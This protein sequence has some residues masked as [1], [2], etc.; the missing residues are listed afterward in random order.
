MKWFVIPS[1]IAGV[2]AVPT[3][4]VL[5]MLSVGKPADVTYTSVDYESFLEKSGV[6]EAMEDNR[7]SLLDLLTD[8]YVK[9]ELT[10]VNKAFTSAEFTAYLNEYFT[11]TPGIADVRVKFCDEGKLVLSCKVTKEVAP[12]LDDVPQAADLKGYLWIADGKTLR[13]EETVTSVDQK[14]AT[15]LDKAYVG[16]INIAGYIP[17]N[18]FLI[19]G[20]LNIVFQPEDSNGFSFN[21]ENGLV[22]VGSMP[23]TIA[24]K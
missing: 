7:A 24:K 18:V 1:I 9:G 19:S 8:N 15:K 22:F 16:Q 23:E 2:I 5:V 13:V 14:I 20:I 4:S 10:R 6:S 3:A 17:D 11:P 12:L 21:E